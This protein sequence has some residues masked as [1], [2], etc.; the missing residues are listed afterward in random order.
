MIKTSKQVLAAAALLRLAILA[1]SAI[2][3]LAW[4]ASYPGS[5]G[6]A[7]QVFGNCENS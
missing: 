4:L 7:W 3:A 1:L 5:D 2:L 6:L